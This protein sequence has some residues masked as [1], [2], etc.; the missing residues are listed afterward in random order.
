VKNQ[1]KAYVF[2]IMAIICWSTVATAFKISLRSIDIY[3]FLFYS[4]VTAV[5]ILF[6]YLLIQKKLFLF[7]SYFGKDY[8]MASVRGLFNPFIYYLVLFE[9][10]RLLPAQEAQSLNYTWPVVLSVM[11]VLFLGEKFK[12]KNFIAILLSFCGVILIS[13][14]GNIT[15]I[16]FSNLKGSIF[17]VSSSV[18]WASYWILNLK[19]K[20]YDGIKLFLNFCFGSI[21][22]FLFCL[23][24]GKLL[25]PETIPLFGAIY[26]GIFEMGLAFI[27]WL[28]AL[29]YAKDTSKVS[30]LIFIA[31]FLSLLFI[32]LIV[33]EKILPSTFFGLLLIISGIIFQQLKLKTRKIRNI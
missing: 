33:K 29:Q 4:S 7:K 16:H 14:K 6:L 20:N 2:A 26:S 25:W 22:I 12:L 3:N 8:L 15:A 31:P 21:Y 19:D 1:K 5:I 10:Y 23:L 9:A 17:A 27:L 24:N 18:F 32:S 30:N 28:K 13:V 11:S